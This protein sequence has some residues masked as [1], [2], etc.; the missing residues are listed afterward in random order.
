[1]IVLD[2]HAWLWWAGDHGKLPP[3][4]RRRLAEAPALAISAISCWEVAMLIER[5]RL[6]L[7]PD[8]RAGIRE[9]CSLPR[10]RVLPVTE[11]VAMEAGLLG[12]DFHGDP[13]D[14]IIVATAMEAR[15]P[16]ATR[17][18]RIRSSRLVE[19]LW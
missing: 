11:Q 16:L 9:A 8:A 12:A 13:A 5:G 1:M 19:T 17:D 18:E 15:A 2:T 3:R 4:L 14:R 10:L 7:A 6:E